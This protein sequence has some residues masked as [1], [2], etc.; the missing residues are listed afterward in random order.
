M[1]L[2][3]SSLTKKYGKK[4]A[5][6]NVSLTLSSGV[7]GLL[8]P[9]GAGKSTLMQ[10]ITMTLKPTS[11]TILWNGGMITDSVTA[12]RSV[13]GYMP[14][15]QALY[16]AFT[17]SDFLYYMAALYGM[18]GSEA[19]TAVHNSLAAVNL[20]NHQN[21]KIKTFSG[22]MKQRLLLAQAILSNPRVLILDEPTAG[23]D[24]YQ[25]VSIRN[26][27][28][29]IAMD[30]IIL[31]ATHVV[32]DIDVISKEVILIK[33]GELIQKGTSYE[34]RKELEGKLFEITI[35]AHLFETMSEKWSI[36]GVR[37]SK[38]HQL[39][40]RILAESIPRDCH[41]REVAPTLEDVYLYKL[42]GVRNE[43]TDLYGI[44]KNNS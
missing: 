5:L 3:I 11:G 44:Q 35:P 14:Q 19:D 39:I 13:L 32:Q 7:Y 17:A 21:Q 22:G 9:N 37:E 12:F 20:L 1:E 15:Q 33:D 34:L 16:P 4:I 27:I 25:R 38:E 30:R 29:Q 26:L 43:E 36:Y 42:G 8:G 10:L 41:A 24:P 23:L 6:N 18:K 31:I 2:K 40:I 28:S